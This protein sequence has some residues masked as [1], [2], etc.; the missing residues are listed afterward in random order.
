MMTPLPWQVFR[1]SPS[2]ETWWLAEGME[3]SNIYFCSGF[4]RDQHS[5]ELWDYMAQAIH[6]T[7]DQEP[8]RQ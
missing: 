3:G 5:S 6:N 4:Q 8:G 1:V 7:V 2:T